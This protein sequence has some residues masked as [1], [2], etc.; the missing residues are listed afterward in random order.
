MTDEGARR[1][2]ARE[3]ILPLRLAVVRRYEET[4]ANYVN[5]AKSPGEIGAITHIE[6]GARQRLVTSQDKKLEEWLGAPLPPESAVSSAYR[7][8]PRMFLSTSRT[9]MAAGQ[10]QEL[11]PFVLSSAKCVGINLYWR[12]LGQGEF[13][14]VVAAHRNRQAYRVSLPPR[15]GGTVEYYLEARLEDGLNVLWPATAPRMNQ[16]V[17]AW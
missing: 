16:T 8:K 7:G 6:Y 13:Q 17:I 3:Q 5:A 4:I 2:F 12:P 11:R 10:P 14:K 1:Q 9:Q 15:S